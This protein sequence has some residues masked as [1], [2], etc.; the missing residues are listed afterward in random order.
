[1]DSMFYDCFSLVT[2][3][4]SNLNTK[5][6]KSMLAMFHCC[7]SLYSLD[8]SHLDLRNVENM[9]KFCYECHSLTLTNFTNMRTLNVTSYTGMFE[10]CWRLTSLEL[11]NFRT[12]NID[13][14]LDY[15]PHLRYIDIQSINCQPLYESSIGYGFSNNGTI[16]IN[17]YCISSIQNTLLNWSIIIC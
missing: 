14:M 13:R 3:K 8:F 11:A 7:Y 4:F 15:C 10:G 12:K 2:I 1:M 5:N 6:V 9:Y 17:S 16:K